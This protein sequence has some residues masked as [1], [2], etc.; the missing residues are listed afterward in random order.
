MFIFFVKFAIQLQLGICNFALY[1][2]MLI[3]CTSETRVL[4][5][6]RFSRGRLDSF[7]FVLFI[8]ISSVGICQFV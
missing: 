6:T 3:L 7:V 1:F 4:V 2:G 8:L 5:L